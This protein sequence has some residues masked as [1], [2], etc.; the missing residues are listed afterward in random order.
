MFKV[1]T[2]FMFSQGLTQAMKLAVGI[3]IVQSL[4]IEQYALY[5]IA[6][7]IL[8]VISLGSNFGLSQGIVTIGSSRREDQGYVG[9][10]YNAA[11][12]WTRRFMVLA[13]IVGIGLSVLL[14]LNSPWPLSIKIAVVTIVIFVGWAQVG[15]SLG[16]AVLNIHHDARSLFHVGLGESGVRVALLPLL[17]IWPTAIA[18]LLT[19]LVG[20]FVA[21]RIALHRSWRRCDRYAEGGPEERRALFRFVAPLAPIILYTIIQGQIA[22]LLLSAYADTRAIA[23]TAALGR[24]GQVFTVFMLLNS[25]LVHPNFARAQSRSDYL[26]KLAWLVFALVALSTAVMISAFLL[27]EWW[28]LIIGDKYA[29]LTRELPIALATSL[30]TLAGASLYYVVIA[31]GSTK[32]QSMAILP[33]FGSQLAFVATHGVRSTWD[34]LIVILLPAVAYTLVQAVLLLTTVLHWPQDQQ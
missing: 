28:L 3:A 26:S 19:N 11:R 30:V 20:A 34:A 25:F 21:S 8:L 16:S 4:P 14:F 27:P 24:L 33:C 5:S 29:G 17:I 7:A 2:V 10:L 22:I 12:W 6:S 1:V 23:E 13:I 9:A 18:A 31:R 15:S 32:W